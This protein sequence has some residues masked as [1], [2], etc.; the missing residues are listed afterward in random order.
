[1]FCVRGSFYVLQLSRKAGSPEGYARV[2]ARSLDGEPID[3]ET[4][5][6]NAE[7]VIV[8][9]AASEEVGVVVAAAEDLPSSLSFSGSKRFELN[10]EL[11]AAPPRVKGLVTV[12]TDIETSCF[13]DTF[14]GHGGLSI[15]EMNVVLQPGS[16]GVEDR[17]DWPH[18]DSVRVWLTGPD[19]E[20]QL[21]HKEKVQVAKAGTYNVRLWSPIPF[22][23]PLDAP[24]PCFTK[25]VRLRIVQ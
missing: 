16:V 4:T 9:G 14:T 22:A 25:P 12:N 24:P 21:E 1:V 11:V 8:H 7:P 13:P 2:R 3:I 17:A 20:T 6:Q 10:V 5:F 18:P 15:E 19:G 23:G